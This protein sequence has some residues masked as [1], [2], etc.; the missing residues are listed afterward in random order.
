M[1][2]LFIIQPRDGPCCLGA[3][4]TRTLGSSTASE[5]E[6]QFD[7]CLHIRRIV[8]ALPPKFCYADFDSGCIVSILRLH[9]LYQASISKDLTYDNAGAAKWSSVELNVAVMCACIPA[10]KPVISAVF[11]RLLSNATRQ[12]TSNPFTATRSHSATYYQRHD[13][14]VELS[15]TRRPPTAT[16][17]EALSFDTATAE[18][19]SNAIHDKDGWSVTENEHIHAK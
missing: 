10:I 1:V 12:T 9:A 16:D 6:D 2:L 14:V 17:E 7:P 3:A 19:A 5:A 13:S 15:H 11:P 18:V 8:G 4:N